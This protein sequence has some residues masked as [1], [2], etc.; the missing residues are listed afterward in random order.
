MAESQ[1]SWGE[2]GPAADNGPFDRAAVAPLL[3]ALPRFS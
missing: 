2:P 3:D 1:P